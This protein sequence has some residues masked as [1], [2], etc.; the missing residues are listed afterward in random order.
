MDI[1]WKN[2]GIALV[3]II[4][5][6]IGL[7]GL[8]VGLTR[9]D[10]L[11]DRNY[12]ESYQFAR[13]VDRFAE[14]LNVLILN[15]LSL[16]EAKQTI[17]ASKEEIDEHRYFYGDLSTQLTN[18]RDQYELK[19]EEALAN[20]QSLADY[21]IAERDRKIEDIT[22][23]FVDDEHVRIKVQMEKEQKLEEHFREIEN[24]RTELL[25]YT[26]TFQYYFRDVNTGEIFTNIDGIDVPI[27]EYMSSKHMHYVRTFPSVNRGFISNDQ[28]FPFENHDVIKQARKA[29][30][31]VFEGYIGLPKNV[32]STN[33]LITE[34]NKHEALRTVFILYVIFSIGVLIGIWYLNR[35]IPMTQF[36]SSYKNL[37][38]WY[39][40]VPV[41]LRVIIFGFSAMLTFVFLTRNLIYEFQYNVYAGF[42]E[43]LAHIV[44]TAFLISITAIQGRLLFDQYR[45][46]DE[47]QGDWKHS[48]VMKSLALIKQFFAN[49]RLGTQVLL[50]IAVIFG[51]GAGAVIVLIEPPVIV[52]YL[53]LLLLIGAPL[54]VLLVRRIR[55]FHKIAQHADKLVKGEMD[56]DLPVVGKSVFSDLAQSLNTLKSGVKISQKEQAKS[57]RLKTELIT[58]VSH[59]LRT[60]LTSIITYTELLKKPDLTN[61]DRSSY[62]EIIDRKS[63]R[64]KILIGDLF[65]VSKMA[66][67]NME[68]SKDKVDLYQLLQ[69]SLAENN[70]RM[71]ESTL[72][73]RC[74]KPE[75][76]IY[77]YV[78]GL[79]MHRVFDN[80]I[81]N[82]LKYSLE[83]TRVYIN[84]KATPQ[85]ATIYFKNV[86]KF[87]LGENTDELFERF[88]RGDVSRNTEGSGLGLAIAKS[89]VDIHGGDMDIEVDGDLFK[90]TITI[91]RIK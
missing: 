29:N 78:D 37:E 11:L 28:P 55:Y 91:D 42:M 31:K 57:E 63:Q 81:G 52:V 44:I 70:E 24:Y 6:T 2:R 48:I 88:K 41:D 66:S 46:I 34:Y 4:L 17:T 27:Q 87:E 23:N 20:S 16:E 12:F 62:V 14:L 64:L 47:I 10:Q 51:F 39:R 90:V 71:Q 54:I 85:K 73:F 84:F 86:T 56:S 8:L 61:E 25:Q 21:Y 83:N 89:I 3:Y 76:A 65:E 72:H 67:G 50:I 30:V 5:L 9:S 49:W 15:K 18:I 79:K 82:I 32:P 43:S 59:D 74:D 35:K 19:I 7:N 45:G 68:L 33:S 40:K 26:S 1:K 69:Q 22:L 77:A 36:V 53:P 75:E 58:N 80:L 60:P 13:E 38:P